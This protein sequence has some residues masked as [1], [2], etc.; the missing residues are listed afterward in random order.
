V[1]T[2]NSLDESA[3]VPDGLIQLPPPTNAAR[4]LARRHRTLAG[5]LLAGGMGQLALVIGGVLVARSLG[6]Q[7]RGYFAL[8]I[9]VPHILAEVGNLGL[10]IALTYYIAR[11]ARSTRSLVTSAVR[12]VA[13]QLLVGAAIQAAVLFTLL[14]DDPWRVKTAAFVSMGVL[15][16]MMS[17]QYALAILQGQQ[18]FRAFNVLRT[19]PAAVY[20]VGILAIFL[21]TSPNLAE[22]TAVH[23]GALLIVGGTSIVCAIRGLPARS[24]H[25]ENPSRRAMISFGIRGLLGYMSP[26]ESFRLD[27]AAIGLFLSPAALG[28]YV[29][30]VSVT[31]LPRFLAQSVGMVAYPRIASATNSRE[32]YRL[33][34]RYFWLTVL[35]SLLVVVPLE[36]T[37]S[38]LIPFFFGHQFDGAVSVTRILLVGTLVLGARRVLADGVRGMGHPGAGSIAEISSW[39][40]L[41][42][43]LVFLLPPF[44]IRGVALALTA[45]WC[46]SLAALLATMAI[47]RGARSATAPGV[48]ENS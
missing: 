7:D 14:H 34:W 12:P 3:G 25:A 1:S 4:S 15:P 21:L 13:I 23:T 33:T 45:S 28:L 5:S 39:A 18:R 8:I 10:P 22:V 31:N 11:D 27:Q 2:T 40:A 38:W 35:I 6:V 41:V 47:R 30:G 19:M 48:T 36:M 43:A 46:I 42:P 9:L 37:A 26:I 29:V 20:S 44:G 24:A 16:G 17:L 32:T